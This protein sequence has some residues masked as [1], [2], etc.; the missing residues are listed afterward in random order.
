MKTER[1]T[2][3]GLVIVGDIPNVERYMAQRGVISGMDPA[4]GLP[5]VYGGKKRMSMPSFGQ[6]KFGFGDSWETNPY[7]RYGDDFRMA[8]GSIGKVWTPGENG[9]VK[10]FD[11]ESRMEISGMANANIVDRVDERVDPAGLDAENFIKNNILLTDHMYFADFGV[12]LVERLEPT[13]AGVEFDAFIG[14]PKV[15]PLTERQRNTRSLTAQKILKTVSI[16]FIPYKIRAP[17]YDAE[18]RIVEPAVVM[19]WEMLEL[20]IVAIPCNAGSTFSQRQLAHAERKKLIVPGVSL[21]E[22]NDEQLTNGDVASENKNNQIGRVKAEDDGTQIQTLIFDK[23]KFTLDEARQWCDEHEFKSDGVDETE[24]SYRFRQRDPDDFM[25]DS[26]RTI[27]I[28][29]GIK[30]VVGR[31]KEDDDEMDEKTAKEIADGIKQLVTLNTTM[32]E[33]VKRN[34]E[35]SETML[36]AIDAKK[37]SDKPDDEMDDDDEE[38]PKGD[39]EK[40][41]AKRVGELEKSVGGIQDSLKSI[42]AVLGK[43]AEN[44]GNE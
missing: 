19:Q 13:D 4:T 34:V 15:A 42:D 20:S 11:P 40:S 41:L 29:D 35:L 33:S 36:R 18:G 38:K 9:T 1:K 37:G 31:L 6:Q 12:G 21:N 2:R 16:G 39:D 5:V 27:E 28:D 44:M 8:R 22:T 7:I 32:A 17:E 25:D 10:A 24:S 14:D 23:E 3:T 26:L 30:A 43:I